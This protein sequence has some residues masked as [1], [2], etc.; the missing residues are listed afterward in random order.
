MII[1]RSVNLRRTLLGAALASAL[2]LATI[3]GRAQEENPRPE[4]RPEE[5]GA[6]DKPELRGEKPGPPHEG[7]PEGRPE[8]PEGKP[9]QADAPDRERERP[10]PPLD[11]GP[12]RDM[13]REGMARCEKPHADG[14]RPATS[15]HRGEGVQPEAAL[16]HLMAAAEHLEAA[17]LH[18]EAGHVRARAEGVKR[19]LQQRGGQGRSHHPRGDQRLGEQLKEI[20]QQH[21]ELRAEVAKLHE[22]L[23]KR[24]EGG[25]KKDKRGS[26][27]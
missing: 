24:H 4:P 19:H 22:E 10:S 17:G 11:G 6:G 9:R 23:R 27:Q 3:P 8:Q 21:E 16:P 5:R 13:P 20:R 14:N 18:D 7:R 1:P 12:R 15:P 2:G 25:K 26:T